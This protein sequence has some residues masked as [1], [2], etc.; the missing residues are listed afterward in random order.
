[1]TIVR[2]AKI[3]DLRNR[4]ERRKGERDHLQRLIDDLESSLRSQER[5]LRRLWKARQIVQAVALTTQ[6][7]LEYHLSEQVSLAME[8]I[9]DSPY[10][11]SLRFEEK[12]GKTEARILFLRKHL[13]FPPLGSAGGGTIDVA[14]FA[15]RVAYLSMR[16]DQKIRP[17]LLLDEPFSQLKGEDANRRALG[18]L[19]EIS[20]Q[21]EIQVISVSDERIPR[22]EIVASSDRVFLIQNRDGISRSSLLDPDPSEARIPR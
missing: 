6:R 17:L 14:A 18:L 5:N 16:Q 1:M 15:L 2:N 3:Q 8:A 4:L 22:E 10:Q 9:F 21:L 13:E 7:R 19:Q 20:H 11:A 12:R